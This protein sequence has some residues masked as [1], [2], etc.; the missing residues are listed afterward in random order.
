[1]RPWPLLALSSLACHA[2][3][4]G[5][6]G[7]AATPAPTS[8]DVADTSTGTASADTGTGDVAAASTHDAATTE[9]MRD[10]PSPDFGDGKPIGCRGK[11][12]FLFV[13]SREGNMK[14]LQDQLVAAFPAFIATIESRFADFD[15]HIMVIDGD[16]DWGD[17]NCNE[18]WCPTK[19]CLREDEC[20]P[21]LY[22]PELEGQPCCFA[23]DYPCD[24]L[25]LITQCDLTWGA[26]VVFPAGRY[27]QNKPCP[28]DGGRR[29]LVKGQHDLAGTFACIAAV[30]NAGWHAI[31]QALTAAMQRPINE[32][33][34][35][36][37]GFLRDDA[38]LMITFLASNPDEGS[39]GYVFQ[40]A[41]A[42]QDAKHGDLESIVMLD[43]SPTA[44]GDEC[45][46]KDRICELV[47]MFPYH[48][49]THLIDPDYGAGFDAAADLIDTACAGFVP[50]G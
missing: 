22:A 32:P 30:G 50:P 35:C 12:D 26:G 14:Y 37:K 44:P 10:L 7:F 41:E 2:P 24:K 29:Y 8:V 13:I 16:E 25:D 6:T 19:T 43:F 42:V 4:T 28:I 27:T 49:R 45:N 38:L 33:G 21:L 20:C 39:D 34:G 1:M 18:N 40:W 3:A 15:Y 48:H 9:P 46:Y 31:G 17:L 11:I 5:Q 23:P 36:N 47:N